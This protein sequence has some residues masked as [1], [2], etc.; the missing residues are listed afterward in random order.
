MLSGAPLS[1]CSFWRQTKHFNNPYYVAGTLHPFQVK[2]EMNKITSLDI[3]ILFQLVK[4]SRQSDRQIAKVLNVSQPTVTRRRTILEKQGFLEYS[5]I[6]NL[7]KLGFEILAFTFG[8][9]NFQE[10]PGTRVEQMKQ[11]IAQNPNMI[12]ISTGTGSGYD[13]IGVSVH[14]DYADYSRTIQNFKTGW[15]KYFETLSSFIVSIQTD[16]I[17]Q[18]LSFKYLVNLVEQETKSQNKA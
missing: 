12:F 2:Q 4:D 17:L 1:S 3:K 5:A 9:W 18:N 8:R 16:K 10:Y 13:R 6:P 11:F 14:R 15:G 7:K